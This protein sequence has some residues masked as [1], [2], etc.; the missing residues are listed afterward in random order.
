[1]AGKDRM[2]KLHDCKLNGGL[3]GQHGAAVEFC[4]ESEDGMLI[5]DNGEYSSQVNYCPV[6]GYKAKKQIGD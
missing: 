1:M 4:F 2:I 5:V 3:Y 6:C